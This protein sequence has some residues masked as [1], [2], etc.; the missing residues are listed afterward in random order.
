MINRRQ[1][2]TAG[3]LAATGLATGVSA[4][5]SIRLTAVAGHPPVFLWVKTMDE[6][7]IPEVDK[8][9][10]ASGDKSKL[11]WTKAWGGT[12]VKLGGESKGIVDGVADLG[13][14]STVF[15]TAKFPL[16]NI[17]YATP[18]STG[19]IALVTRLINELQESIPAMGQ[20]WTKNGL[21][22]LGGAALDGYNM[23]TNFPL[24]TVD[25]LKGKKII[26][27]GPAANW[28]KGTGAVAV[29][30]NLNTYY[31]DIKSGVADGVITFATGAWGAKVHE[32]A[33]YVTKINF[34]SQ[35][36]GGMAMNKS[37]FDRLP[38]EVQKIFRDVAAEYEKRFAEAQASTA[39][40]LLQKMEGAGAR[41]SELSPA[42]RK[43]WADTLP[44]IAKT[45]AADLQAKGMPGDH[46]LNG[47][48]NGLKKAGAQPARDWAGK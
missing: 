7:F 9:L 3:L 17:C 40:G 29:A 39:A 10:A 1:I 37:R 47:F 24:R 15:E 42:E 22:Y 21:V 5:Q 23:W 31:E 43:R 45:W 36:A 13:F 30:G 35:F 25:D 33:P 18:F 27:P 41:I 16:Q 28:I 11:E 14:V 6:F 34:G 38:P 4:Q 32:V 2:T 48:M 26:A 12:L 8:L 46:V 19:D 44:P 20:A